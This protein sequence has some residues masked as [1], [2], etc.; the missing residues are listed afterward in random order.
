MLSGPKFKITG[1]KISGKFKLE[2]DAYGE[3][4]QLWV[5]VMQEYGCSMKE[6][7]K[8]GREDLNLQV[9]VKGTCCYNSHS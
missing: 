4:D 1:K 5:E 7:E 6:L 9:V 8:R 3:I 2:L